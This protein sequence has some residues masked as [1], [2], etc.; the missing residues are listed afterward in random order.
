M[1]N[2]V[3]RYPTD[4]LHFSDVSAYERAVKFPYADHEPPTVTNA[5]REIESWFAV[6]RRFNECGIALQAPAVIKYA[7]DLWLKINSE[8][9]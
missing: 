9:K 5:R 2:Q 6:I 8:S 3:Y 4:K 1:Q 7:Y